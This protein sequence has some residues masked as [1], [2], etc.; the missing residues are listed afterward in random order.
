MARVVKHGGKVIAAEARA[1]LSTPIFNLV[2]QKVDSFKRS[3]EI[4]RCPQFE[5][6]FLLSCAQNKRKMSESDAAKMVR[7]VGFEPTLFRVSD[8]STHNV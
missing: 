4:K 3:S 8:F 7:G 2:F 6:V 5:V 1:I